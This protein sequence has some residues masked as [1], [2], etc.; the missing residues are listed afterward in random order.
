VS[1]T[2]ELSLQQLTD[3][4]KSPH[5]AER[6]HAAVILGQRRRKARKAVPALIGALKDGDKSVRKAAALA[7]GDIGPDASQAVAALAEVL[8]HDEESAVRRRAAVAL[9]EIGSGQAIAVLERV[10]TEDVSEEV[11]EMAALALAQIGTRA[12]RAAA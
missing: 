4:L 1:A 11:C 3:R 12:G 2:T 5:Q 6:L 7:L 9:G 10:Y 8:L